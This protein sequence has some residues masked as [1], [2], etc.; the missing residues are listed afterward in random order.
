MSRGK[1]KVQGPD[2]GVRGG[3]TPV[4][5]SQG[6]HKATAVVKLATTWGQDPY[7]SL[8]WERSFKTGRLSV[9]ETL[10]QGTL[11]QG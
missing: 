3:D 11:R 10:N 7:P 1:S 9:G 8:S 2:L 6:V 4:W 5:I